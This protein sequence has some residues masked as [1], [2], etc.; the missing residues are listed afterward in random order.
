VVPASL[1]ARV[2]IDDVRSFNRFYTRV[3]GVLDEGIV[4]T[5]YSLPEAR[6]LFELAQA[7]ERDVADV[8]RALNLDAGYL[9]R[10]LAG[11]EQQQLIE[12]R[13]SAHDARRQVVRLTDRGQAEFAMLDSRSSDQVRGLVSR[14]AETE[15]RRLSAAL[16][17]I[18]DLL[19]ET[20]RASAPI[21]RAPEP[22]DLGW[23]I[24]RHGALYAAE[25]GW[26]G[27][28]EALS[29]REVAEFAER[30]DR[31]RERAWIAE[32][33]GRRVGSVICT[34]RDDEVAQL[35]MLFVDP[36]ARGLGIGALLID[37]CV[38]FAR[39]AGYHSMLLWTT[40]VLTPARRL[41]DR[42]GFELVAQEPF[43]GFGPALVGEY[44]RRVL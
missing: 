6:V 10:M 32:V 38:G 37:T 35:R 7:D 43:D 27:R 2:A 3:I 41:Y 18:R 44:W 17:A 11:L 28:I 24:E 5:P 23:I 19:G 26:N 16:A 34:R 25:Y 20:A 15:Q 1:A 22:G 33:D 12:R 40:S 13:R 4:E 31:R 14:L 36:E 29:A 42:A 21:V 30:D 39:E 8:R 9:S